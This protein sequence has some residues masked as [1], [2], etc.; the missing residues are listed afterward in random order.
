MERVSFPSADQGG[1][2]ETV[3]D[4]TENGQVVD[5]NIFDNKIYY[6]V[7]NYDTQ[8]LEAWS[9]DPDGQNKVYIGNIAQNWSLYA[10]LYM[11]DG[12]MVVRIWDE[13]SQ[14]VGN[15]LMRLDDGSVQKIF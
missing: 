14:T 10:G 3:I 1:E 15:Y 5:F 6:L 9:C 7:K 12:Y 11:A 8:Y 2:R 4:N 13:D